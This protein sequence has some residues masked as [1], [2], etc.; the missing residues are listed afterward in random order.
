[1]KQFLLIAVSLIISCA[2]AVR[3]NLPSEERARVVTGLEVFLEDD[4]DEY[5]GKKAAIITNPTG[6]D[7][8]LNSN[9]SL[10]EKKGI[11]ISLVF[12]PEH[13][14]FGYTDWPANPK[15]ENSLSNKRT[16]LHIQSM[17]PEKVRASLFGYDVVFFDIQDMGMRCYTYISE[18]ACII[19]ALDN[20]GIELIV[21]DR[22]NPLGVYG[23]DGIML[24][25]RLR[26]RTT[27]YFPS[28]LSYGFT[29]G[30]AA[31]YYKD[32]AKRKVKLRVI[33]ME[34]YSRDLYYSETSLPWVPPSPN[35]PTY[36]SAIIYSAMVYFEGT[37][38]SV[39]RGTPNP[40]EY[41]GAPWIDAGTLASQLK[42]LNL[43]GFVF[44]PVFFRPGSS[45]YAGRRCGG[46]Q[47]F[48]T[49]ET[50]S[51]LENAYKIAL[52]LRHNYP[53]FKWNLDWDGEYGIDNLAGNSIFRA[54][55]DGQKSYV[56]LM[57]LVG[58]DTK[59]FAEVS[60]EY[61]LY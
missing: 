45:R 14:L 3:Y 9:I 18:L 32:I 49:G 10:L 11:N 28:T 4:A 19:D 51:P 21:L 17:S 41:I 33:E 57:K 25:S 40:F 24:D 1:M 20:T 55:V 38:L 5:K 61:Y 13:G 34:G 29:T 56:D 8:F 7:R 15:D 35:L 23:I 12:A 16:I 31:V 6:V 53:E 48:I 43:K 58:R 2:S 42:K 30:E 50:F 59:L 26:N 37:N 47:I 44:R 52:L 39:G 22:P 36:K 27:S 54:Y 60:E 46:V